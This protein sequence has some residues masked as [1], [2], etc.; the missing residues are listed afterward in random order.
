MEEQEEL[1]TASEEQQEETER[2]NAATEETAIAEEETERET[3]DFS[4]YEEMA[5]KDLAA[6]VALRPEY[7]VCRHLSELPF[8]ERFAQLRDLGLSCE[9]ALAAADR[10]SHAR[11]NKNHLHSVLPRTGGERISP[12]ARRDLAAA[13]EIFGD[14]ISEKELADLYRRA[15][16]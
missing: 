1:L 3:K 14:R 7:A 15:T 10:T 2:E 12:S 11:G 6:I 13:R 9:E 4:L 16:R 8:A 5:R